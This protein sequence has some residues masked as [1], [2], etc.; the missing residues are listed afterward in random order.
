MDIGKS[1]I[2]VGDDEDWLSKL[3]LG[4]IIANVPILNLAWLGYLTDIM[5]NVSDD[6]ARPLP[7]WSDFG[8]KF[9]KGLKLVGAAIIYTLP[10]MLLLGIPLVAVIIA[11]IPADAD[12][13]EVIAATFAGAGILLSCCIAIYFLVFAF[14]FPAINLNFARRG[15]FGSCFQIKDIMQLVFNN[16]G[17]YLIA[18]LV[19][20]VAALLVSMAVSILGIMLVLVPCIGWILMIVIGGVTNVWIGTIYAHLVGQVGASYSVDF[21]EA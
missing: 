10:G 14:L 13:Q 8:D 5:R 12:L 21:V 20:W 11:G 15:T 9:L 17:E 19:S 6:I 3:I 16:F 18:L 1:I 2:Y 7:D 4:A